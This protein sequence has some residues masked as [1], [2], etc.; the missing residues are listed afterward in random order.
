[1][2]EIAYSGNQMMFHGHEA[3]VAEGKRLRDL[4]RSIKGSNAHGEQYH[5]LNP[6]VYG[7]VHFVFYESTLTCRRLFGE[8]VTEDEAEFLFQDWR[9]SGRYFGLRDQDL[10]QSRQQYWDK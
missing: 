4:H 8:G 10:P 1:M 9:N 3:A 5:A 6:A 7:W 2:R